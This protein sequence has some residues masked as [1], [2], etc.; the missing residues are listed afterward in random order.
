MGIRTSPIDWKPIVRHH[1]FS[2]IARF[3]RACSSVFDWEFP[4]LL[5]TLPF[6]RT[7]STALALAWSVLLAHHTL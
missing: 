6:L 5:N 7:N 3:S 2:R 4:I 1:T